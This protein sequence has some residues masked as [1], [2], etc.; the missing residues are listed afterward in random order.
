MSTT[1][2][3]ILRHDLAV[4][5]HYVTADSDLMLQY[6]GHAQVRDAYG[7]RLVMVFR[8]LRVDLPLLTLDEHDADKC[9]GFVPLGDHL[10]HGF[11]PPPE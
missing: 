6:L 3:W 5:E 8:D 1:P 7:F 10:A 2:G 4:G 11:T 9:A